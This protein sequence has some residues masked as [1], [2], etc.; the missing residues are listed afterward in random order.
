MSHLPE[1]QQEKEAAGS[2]E[3]GRNSLIYEKEMAKDATVLYRKPLRKSGSRIELQE[4]YKQGSFW[5]EPLPWMA[6]ARRRL[7]EGRPHKYKRAIIGMGT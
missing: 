3:A 4:K 6:Q 7:S 2:K 1:M 5:G